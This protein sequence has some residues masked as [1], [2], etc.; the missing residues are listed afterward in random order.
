MSSLGVWFRAEIEDALEGI[1]LAYL[2]G[3]TGSLIDSQTACHVRGFFAALNAVALAFGITLAVPHP[4]L[5]LEG[6]K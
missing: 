6:G 1:W 2:A 5:L 4:P 3:Q